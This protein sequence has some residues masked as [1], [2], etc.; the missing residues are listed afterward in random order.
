MTQAFVG[1]R[2]ELAALGALFAEVAAGVPK[3]LLVDGEA[4]IGKTTLVERFLASQPDVRVLRASGDESESNV[5]FAIVD[6]LLRSAGATDAGVLAAGEHLT[7]G[8]QLLERLNSEHGDVVVVDDAH[9]ADAD[10]LRALLFC[11]RRL[12]ESATLLV[13]I[14]RG[15][16]AEVLPEGWLKLA[17]EAPLRPC[18]LT[19][20]EVRALGEHLG[21]ALNADAAGRLVEHTGGNPLHLRALLRELPAAGSWLHDDRPL[22]APR[23]YARLIDARF[24]RCEPDVVALLSAL[25][26]LGV[27]SPLPSVLQLAGLDDP[28]PT[29]DCAVES[30]LV[31]VSD[32]DDG[33]WLEFSHPLTRA[34]VYDAVPL[35]RRSA[36][37]RAAAE[38]VPLAAAALHHRV[39]AVVVPDAALQAELETAAREQG[40]RGAWTSAVK[41]LLAASRMTAD[42]RD[43]ERLTLDAIEA[44]LYSGDGGAARRLAER[45]TVGESAR[46]DSVWAYLAMFTGDSERAAHLLGRAWEHRGDDGRLAATVAQRRAFMASSRLQGAEAVEWARRAMALAPDDTGVALLAA[47][48]LANG[49][50]FEGRL[51]EAHAVLDRWLDDRRAPS[52]GS[53]FVLLALKARLLEAQGEIGR[54]GALFERSADVSLSE[55]LLV[56][57]AMSLAGGARVQYL[58]GAWDDAVVSAERAIAVAIESEDRWVVAHARW[59]SAFVADARG[60]A[61]SVERLQREVASDPATFERHTAL[62]GVFAAQLAAS[63]DRPADVLAALAPLA[64]RH[65]ELTL[66]GWH[67]RQAHALVDLGRLDA[68]EAFAREAE[69]LATAR[70]QPLLAARLMH[71]RARI[72]FARHAPEEATAALTR[73]REIVEPLRMPYEQALL[74][75]AHAQILR[76]EGKRR[77]A[78]E[79]LLDAR[80]R[81]AALSAVP[82]LNRCER[83]LTACGLRPA[84]R[85][86]KD[87]AGLT[88]QET[89]VAR[90]VVSGMT[91]REVAK[92]LMLSAKT[93]EF[94]LSNVYLKAG[95]RSRAELRTRARNDDLRL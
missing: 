49:L 78:S 41:Y 30:G 45:M 68:A 55:G 52:P 37:H 58:A 23:R 76:R 91:N 34:A 66:L 33:S 27:R 51:E 59:S 74:E 25:A 56:I 64:E 22:P 9:L 26:V 95:V 77:A 83:E 72:A 87:F 48:S 73:A 62:Q 80:E 8:L 43:R 20:A 85:S 57:A 94:H 63:Q 60:D 67:D 35:A 46:R 92:E 5:S 13:L 82:A 10:S 70:R 7:V 1:R 2:E 88:P 84:P 53:G 31:R 40:A 16:A 61:D 39:E 90:L 93:V 75:L 86:A 79:L 14:V 18:A 71:A 54:A 69:A 17:E 81:F 65:P 4:G 24:S 50:A 36:L 15:S 38:I 12:A 3:V 47:P 6:Q 42:P 32:R 29:I 28:L 21:I 44:L 11:A 89:A 19:A